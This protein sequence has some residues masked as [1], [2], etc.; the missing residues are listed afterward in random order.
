MAIRSRDT[1]KPKGKQQK[2]HKITES[3]QESQ[4]LE[5][6]QPYEGVSISYHVPLHFL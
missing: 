3:A 5:P 2:A 1:Q 4:Y 6:Q